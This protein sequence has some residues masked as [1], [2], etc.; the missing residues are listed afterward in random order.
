MIYVY[1]LHMLGIHPSQVPHDVRA[2]IPTLCHIALV[3][4]LQH[5]LM[6][7]FRV[8]FVGEACSIGA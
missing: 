2:P 7:S 6:H 4:K 5:D 1:G 3:A 8:V